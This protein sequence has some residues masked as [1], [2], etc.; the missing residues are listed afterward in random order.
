MCPTHRTDGLLQCKKIRLCKGK[1]KK[2][3][4]EKRKHVHFKY[5]FY[6]FN[7]VNNTVYSFTFPP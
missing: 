7:F 6:V 1:E 4:V 3:R 2:R 5:Y